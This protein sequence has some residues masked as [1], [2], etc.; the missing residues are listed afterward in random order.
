[1]QTI[2]NLKDASIEVIKNLP[3]AATLDDIMYQVNLVAKVF[4]GLEDE[5][6]RNLISSEELL[7][8]IKLWKN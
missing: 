5:D 6:K 8:E 4:K 2:T 7:N 1:M 3:K